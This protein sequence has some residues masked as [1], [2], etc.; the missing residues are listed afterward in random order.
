ML[1]NVC[2]LDRKHEYCFSWV[3]PFPYFC[4]NGYGAKLSTANIYKKRYISEFAITLP[5][6]FWQLISDMFLREKTF[7]FFFF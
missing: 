4:E 5:I 7:G 3:L 6:N 1:E 2:Y